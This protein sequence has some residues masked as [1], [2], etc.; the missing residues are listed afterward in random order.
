M[1]Y[2][3]RVGNTSMPIER[4]KRLQKK[5][6]VKIEEDAA[7]AN[8][9]RQDNIAASLGIKKPSSITPDIRPGSELSKAIAEDFDE[10]ASVKKRGRRQKAEVDVQAEG[11]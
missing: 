3:I 8:K 6:I 1:G 7:R 11:E 4:F 9:I 5:D 10:K 2:Y